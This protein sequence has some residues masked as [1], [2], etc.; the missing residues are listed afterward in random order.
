M[1]AVDLVLGLVAYALGGVGA[2]LY[3]TRAVAVLVL[4]PPLVP[5]QLMVRMRRSPRYCCGFAAARVDE[6]CLACPRRSQ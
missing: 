5:A 3:V 6:G 1:P 2:R 4:R